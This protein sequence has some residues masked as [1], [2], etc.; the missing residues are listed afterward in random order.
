MQ[1]HVSLSAVACEKQTC[2]TLARC[3]LLCY[4]YPHPL[5]KKH[6]VLILLLWCLASYCKMAI[7]QTQLQAPVYDSLFLWGQGEASD[8]VRL[9]TRLQNVIHVWRNQKGGKRKRKEGRKKGRK[10]SGCF[11]PRAYVQKR[12]AKPV[13]LMCEGRNWKERSMLSSDQSF[14]RFSPPPPPPSPLPFSRRQ[15]RACKV[16]FW[17]QIVYCSFFVSFSLGQDLPLRVSYNVHAFFL[18]FLFFAFI[19]LL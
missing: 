15:Q 1:L 9:Q 5:L 6:S 11:C 3:F 8:W 10:E 7:L 19:S 14:V 12:R 16:Q 13:L 4:P 17:E 2:R 18:S